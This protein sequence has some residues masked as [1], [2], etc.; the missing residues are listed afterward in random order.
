MEL[1]FFN[2]EESGL[3]YI[4]YKESR[5]QLISAL[6]EAKKYVDP[7]EMDLEILIVQVITRL[8]AL[9]DDEFE[10]VKGEIVGY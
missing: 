9:S 6:N 10:Q 3:V 4:Y 1:E 5:L 2:A 7:D 8:E